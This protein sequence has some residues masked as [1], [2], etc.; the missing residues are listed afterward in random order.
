MTIRRMR[1][2]A[3]AGM[4]LGLPCLA[5]AQ[6]TV[7][8]AVARTPA[9]PPVVA[10]SVPPVPQD[11][12]APIASLGKPVPL[13]P[14][15]AAV[16][17]Q[18]AIPPLVVP[19]A[20]AAPAQAAIERVALVQVGR[21]TPLVRAQAP[22]PDPPSSGPF[23]PPPFP[24]AS[25]I[26]TTVDR[27]GSEGG[28]TMPLSGSAVGTAPPQPPV[29]DA[30]APLTPFSSGAPADPPPP[31]PPAASPPDFAPAIATDRPVAPGFWEKA[32]GWMDWG[33]KGGGNRCWLQSDKDFN[34]LISPV[35]NPFFFEDPRALTEVRPIFMYQSVPTSNGGGSAFFFGTQARVAFT[36]RF[37]VVMNE[38]GFVSLSPSGQPSETGFAEIKIG[39]KY[40]FYRNCA[41]GTVAAAGLTFEIPAGS[42]KVFQDTGTLGL[43]PYITFGQTFGR[44]PNGFGSFNLLYELGY[45]FATDNQRSEFLHSSLHLDYN[46]ANSCTFY[47]LIEFN[48]FHY[49][50]HG[51]NTDLGFEGGDLVNFGS[52]TRRGSDVFIIALGGRYRFTDNIFAGAAVEFPVTRERGL[53]DYRLTF[54]VIFR[55]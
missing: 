26:S 25:P 17:V 28:F 29:P 18:R 47:P 11:A 9:P 16:T 42:S 27:A 3:A 46:V 39:P 10:S 37:S 36:E 12:A 19:S 8:R 32:R 1:W 38:L 55:Y 53:E 49:T 34:G 2:L 48:W 6:D 51:H 30:I 54:D 40:T 33:D 52:M 21:P 14:R 35:T 50:G 24:P 15:P 20:P 22:D 45:S 31:L 41:T 5:V 43:D 7:W 23:P 4:A 44:L 13:A